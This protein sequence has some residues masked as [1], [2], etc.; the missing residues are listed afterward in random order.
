MWSGRQIAKG[1]RGC[2]RQ[3]NRSLV[4][5][6]VTVGT[7]IDP[8]DPRHI[9]GHPDRAGP[10]RHRELDEQVAFERSGE[11]PGADAATYIES[12]RVPQVSYDNPRADGLRPLRP[13]R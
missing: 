2:D 10:E 12:A 9:P 1:K 3:V 11:N 7:G 5:P 8:I 13:L 6:H 4:E